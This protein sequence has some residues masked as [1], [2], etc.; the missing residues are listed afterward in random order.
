MKYN[1]SNY[2]SFWDLV[3]GTYL[4]GCDPKAQE[5]YARGRAADEAWAGNA[6]QTVGKP[7][8]SDQGLST[9]TERNELGVKGRVVAAPEKA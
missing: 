8:G 9:A 1:F 2:A 3:L 7:E 4:S 6:K 5:K